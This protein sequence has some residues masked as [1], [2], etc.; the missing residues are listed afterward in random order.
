MLLNFYFVFRLL[1]PL[2]KFMG[3]YAVAVYTK[4]I[5]LTFLNF[6]GF[7]S[8]L[9]NCFTKLPKHCPTTF[10]LWFGIEVLWALW[11]AFHTFLFLLLD[12]LWLCFVLLYFKFLTTC[13]CS[14]YFRFGL[15]VSPRKMLGAKFHISRAYPI[16]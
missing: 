16:L 2:Q 4:T 6:P 13:A 14:F 9:S 11:E 5:N 15:I 1:L 3:G 8:C 10:F 7:H 12:I